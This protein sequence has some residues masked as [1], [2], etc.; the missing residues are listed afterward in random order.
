M[1]CPTC[2][3]T[4]SGTSIEG[5]SLDVCKEGCGGIWFDRFELHKMDEPHEFT[6]ENLVEMLSAESKVDHDETK[7]HN[8]PKCSDMVM[9]RN[10]FSVKRE[11]EVDHCPQC[12][13]Y[14]LDEGELFHIR[15]QF[16]TEEERKEAAMNHF[17]DLFDGE[18]S[19]MREESTEK[20]E[21]AKK[22]AHM[23]RLIT[24]SYYYSKLKKW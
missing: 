9:M 8:C 14:W 20:A 10:H 11:L 7:R 1:I 23:L 3:G 6:D 4:L 21:Q 5:I 24:P 22:I 19:E 15:K 18:L 2:N 16:K 12:A 13:G 17:S